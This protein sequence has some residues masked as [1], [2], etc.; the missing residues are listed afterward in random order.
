MQ[1]KG[2]KQEASLGEAKLELVLVAHST[3][4]AEMEVK[5]YW[6]ERVSWAQLE[7]P[8]RVFQGTANIF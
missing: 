4:E 7:R 6:T 3:R 2:K 1:L 8:K 5:L